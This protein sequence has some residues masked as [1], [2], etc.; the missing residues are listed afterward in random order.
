ME[1]CVDTWLG[2]LLYIEKKKK[3]NNN[4]VVYLKRRDHYMANVIIMPLG[5]LGDRWCIRE[6]C[7]V[8]M[9]DIAPSGEAVHHGTV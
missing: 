5:A 1:R 3:K 8:I 2:L 6:N 9:D 7:V 4:S